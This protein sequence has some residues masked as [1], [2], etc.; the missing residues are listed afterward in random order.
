MPSWTWLAHQLLKE[1][2]SDIRTAEQEQ[3]V[4]YGDEEQ[5]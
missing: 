5:G 3:E 1:K 4:A 2:F